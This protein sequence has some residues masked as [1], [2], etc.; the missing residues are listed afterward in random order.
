[1]G[2][3]S[4]RGISKERISME[5]FFYGEDFSMKGIF[6]WGGFFYEGDFSMEEI[7]L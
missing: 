5:R 2:R 4:K 6:L 7:F 3:I 1:M